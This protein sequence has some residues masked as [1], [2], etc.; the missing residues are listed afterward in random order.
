[1]SGIDDPRLREIILFSEQS[2][3][4]SPGD[5]TL[6]DLCRLFTYSSA[7]HPSDIVLDHFAVE[8]AEKA[9]TEWTVHV[10]VQFAELFVR[11]SD[12][13]TESIRA[14]FAAELKAK[15][16]EIPPAYSSRIF[17]TLL[18]CQDGPIRKICND[19]LEMNMKSLT[20]SALFAI[21]N[22][23]SS[24]K[25]EER[26]EF[27]HVRTKAIKQ[28]SRFRALLSGEDRDKFNSLQRN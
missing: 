28:L 1:M 25:P 17:C 3:I 14:R 19:I 27:A 24:L 10:L 2:F 11:S 8:I 22:A 7:S 12:L 26:K 20:P 9:S 18:K 13:N 4:A 6:T 16:S 23:L 21:L 5:F 15:A